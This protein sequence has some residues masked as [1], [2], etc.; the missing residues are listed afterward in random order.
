[1][2]YSNNHHRGNW[3]PGY[4]EGFHPY[5]ASRGSGHRYDQRGYGRGHPREGTGK[6][7]Q[8]SAQYSDTYGPQNEYAGYDQ[9]PWYDDANSS[10]GNYE[11]HD[12]GRW[13]SQDEVE[14][15]AQSRQKPIWSHEERT[16]TTNGWRQPEIRPTASINVVSQQDGF[17]NQSFQYSQSSAPESRGGKV[18]GF[19]KVPQVRQPDGGYEEYQNRVRPG[20]VTHDTQSQAQAQNMHLNV[21]ADTL[22][23]YLNGGSNHSHNEGHD[24]LYD[25]RHHDVDSH[26]KSSATRQRG[27]Q[28]RS[29]DRGASFP[30]R[31]ASRM[32]EDKKSPETLS[33]DNPF[34]NFPSKSSTNQGELSNGRSLARN[35]GSEDQSAMNR[36]QDGLRP[37]PGANM[38]PPNSYERSRA[39]PSALS[40]A[41]PESGLILADDSTTWQEPGAVS[42]YYG[43]QDHH[44][45]PDRT[46][47]NVARPR[48]PSRSQSDGL[49]NG[50]MNRV[51]RVE[52]HSPNQDRIPQASQGV[53]QDTY[54]DELPKA[55]VPYQQNQHRPRPSPI[56]EDLPNFE[57]VSE[58]GVQQPTVNPD[59]HFHSSRRLEQP[60]FMSAHEI[61]HRPYKQ[62]GF[63]Q[64][65]YPSRS[66]S[67]PDF[68]EG[69]PLGRRN[70]DLNS[71][72]EGQPDRRPATSASSRNELAGDFRP[73]PGH[74]GRGSPGTFAPAPGPATGPAFGY[75]RRPPL[76]ALEPQRPNYGASQPDRHNPPSVPNRG[77]MSADFAA[78]DQI[79]GSDARRYKQNLR[80]PDRRRS[81]IKDERNPGVSGHR[82]SSE[83]VPVTARQ[84]HPSLDKPLPSNPDALPHHPGP[85]KSG[86]DGG[87][88]SGHLAR[89]VPVRQYDSAPADPIQQSAGL[90]EKKGSGK[91]TLHE[92][93]D[94]RQKTHRNPNDSAMQ[95]V[96]AQ[97]LVEAAE[98]LVDDRA[99]LNT[100]K[101]NRDRYQS[102]AL[103]IVK[104]L[105]A[106]SYADADFYYGDCYSR[107]ALG[108]QPD[109]REA[110][111]LYQK[112][113]KANHA[114][115]AYR[116]A[117]CCELGQEEG[118][119]TKRDAVKAMQWYRRAA[120]LGDVAAMYK[121]GVILLKGLLG[122][123]RNPSEG[124]SFLKQAADRADK[125]NPHALHELALLHEKST[126]TDSI[127]QDEAYSRQL[128]TQ[129]ANLGYKFSQFRLGCAYEYGALSCPVDPRQSIAWYSKA[130][131][132]E[133]HQSELALSGWY[134]TG[135]DG[136]LQQSDTEAYLWAR[137]AAQAGL[138]K[139]EYAMGYFTE[140]GIGAPA[141]LEDAKR[142]YWKSASQNFP[143]ARD[144]LEDLRKGGGPKQK[145]RVS[146]SNMRKQSDGECT[147]M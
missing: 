42:G 142:W 11:A 26:V 19:P 122:Q 57:A 99:D 24:D 18:Q 88:L 143:K 127:R 125:E 59:E 33:W 144:R 6:P 114:Q 67:Q 92:L 76:K 102:D 60:P 68:M 53:I 20:H 112:A 135:S 31:D 48:A 14:Y 132:Q 8:Y 138:A 63:Q 101:R 21:E 147:V 77:D 128:F 73:P 136:I 83:S 123:P 130:A 39:M 113:A 111:V 4:N 110:F 139:A 90:N 107:G 97:K 105:S 117:V 30:R 69:P 44:N 131:V 37:S 34:P 45:L 38:S 23:R 118:G 80:Q 141:N 32:P 27:L 86:L 106:V 35:A 1:M 28:T 95:L 129:A 108:L 120:A 52:T 72:L 49:Y 140:V 82:T 29:N 3:A 91:V 104:K 96:L 65:Q 124:I 115:A 55:H 12:D 5:S 93:E 54:Q 47:P 74:S 64:E 25:G 87:Q 56:D 17:Y 137:K 78:R 85:V 100:K 84:R 36:N 50:N 121:L 15:P 134:L 103:R 41:V 66:R 9:N 70:R 22:P 133:E 98:V 51:R 89:P 71:P 94:L 2:A 46:V 13:R 116:V 58:R 109:I 43:P 16:Q 145:A 40:E 126:G 81:P 119:G 7:P 10:G 61:S 146:R 62:G 79:R 75:D